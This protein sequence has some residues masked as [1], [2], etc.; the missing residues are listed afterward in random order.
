MA[1]SDSRWYTTAPATLRKVLAEIPKLGTPAKANS[2]WLASI[3][4]SSGNAQSMLRVF[5]NVGLVAADGSPTE[6]WPAFRGGDNKAL[7]DGI[8]AGYAQL[9]GIYPDAHQKD[10]EAL[11]SFFRTN[12]SLAQDAQRM[13]V[14]TFQALCSFADFSDTRETPAVPRV[15]QAEGAKDE[16][17]VTTNRAKSTAP[18]SAGGVGLTVNIQLQLPPSA[19]GEVYDKLFEAMAK[20]L[21]GLIDLE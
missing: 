7:A 13:C 18:R 20:H 1:A 6:L 2:A 10:T 17:E 4:H 12:T 11:M 19:D 9:F 16:S 5:K 8:R 3:G 15:P 21:R 14:Q